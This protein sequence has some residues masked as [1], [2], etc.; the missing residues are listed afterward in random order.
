MSPLTSNLRPLTICYFQQTVKKFVNLDIL[1]YFVPKRMEGG[2]T[3]VMGLP[4]LLPKLALFLK[5]SKMIFDQKNEEFLSS[6]FTTDEEIFVVWNPSAK[7]REKQ[8]FLILS[9]FSHN[10]TGKLI[11]SQKKWVRHIIWFAFC[12]WCFQMLF[13]MLLNYTFD[14]LLHGQSI[15]S[16]EI[17]R[18][19]FRETQAMVGVF[20]DNLR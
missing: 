12:F 2:G 7:H 16:I 19:R 17:E 9:L 3:G 18:H 1:S 13:L 10:L 8:C 14:A 4:P 6:Y 15:Q 5:A 11:F 20:L